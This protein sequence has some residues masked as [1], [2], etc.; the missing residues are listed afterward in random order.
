MGTTGIC[1]WD[2]T[3]GDVLGDA[4]GTTCGFIYWC[5]SEGQIVLEGANGPSQ[6]I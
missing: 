3:Q 5:D 2:L 4:G 6:G 1:P